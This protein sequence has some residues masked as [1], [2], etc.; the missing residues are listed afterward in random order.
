MSAVRSLSD[1]ARVVLTRARLNEALALDLERA[2]AVLLGEAE[3]AEDADRA[4]ARQVARQRLVVGVAPRAEWRA[5]G[6]YALAADGVA[7]VPVQGSLGPARYWVWTSYEDIEQA[8]RAAHADPDV[9]AVLLLIDSPGGY[10]AGVA[11][12]AAALQ[13]AAAA[14]GK[15]TAAH[16]DEL[17]ASAAYWLAATADEVTAPYSGLAGSI[18]ALIVHT[19][20][21]G[22][23]GKLGLT[24]SVIRS[25]PRKAEANGLEPLSEVARAQLA[26]EV[27]VAADAFVAHVAARR[28]LAP[29]AVT[30]L[31]AACLAADQALA[32][33]LLDAVLPARAALERLAA[34]VQAARAQSNTARR[35]SR[36]GGASAP[37][38]C[39]RSGASWGGRLLSPQT[40]AAIETAGAHT[41]LTPAQKAERRNRIAAI[42]AEEAADEAVQA[43]QYDEIE[44]IV[45]EPAEDAAEPEGERAPAEGAAAR[46]AAERAEDARALALPEAAGR[47]AAVLSMRAA[48]MK[49]DAIAGVLKGLGPVPANTGS[50]FA[51]AREAAAGAHLRPGAAVEGADAKPGDRLLA[52]AR[53]LN[54]KS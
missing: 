37:A 44:A 52:A 10:V 4:R 7:I 48:G 13:E 19:E 30:A 3:A 39:P 9:G 31:E 25:A 27:G 15:P 14:S 41:M 23:M 43:A 11:D 22:L 53:K 45:N 49:A 32:H 6:L 51:A 40:I 54:P 38:A 12:C 21:A 2:G 42:T 36:L 5:G 47:H 16:A 33:G 18:G 35:S 17:A 34:R 50:R 29:E 20:A 24:A 26:H 8:A 46:I 28:K 1:L